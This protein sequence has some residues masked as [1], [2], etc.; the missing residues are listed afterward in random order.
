MA[1]TY[2][3]RVATYG[4]QW[5]RPWLILLLPLSIVAVL[6]LLW[7]QPRSALPKSSEACL[8]Q[9]GS[10]FRSPVYI[11]DLPWTADIDLALACA[12]KQKRRVLLAFHAVTDM[13]ARYNERAVFPLEQVKSGLRA[14][15]LLVLYIDFVPESF[16]RSAPGVD[17]RRKDGE[18]NLTFEE[19]RFQTAQEPLYAVL[20]PKADA[21]F[22]IVASYKEGRI[23]NVAGF[24]R[25][26]HEAL[27][28]R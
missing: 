15:V 11:D 7:W 26:L 19:Q 14:Y 4:R 5:Y 6:H 20:E 9:A 24:V 1:S 28:E 18:A 23:V 12:S 27:A 3:D 21:G 22:E 13:N 10:R 8:S 25:F 17:E 2:A 16:C